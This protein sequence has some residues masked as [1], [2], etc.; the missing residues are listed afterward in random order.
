MKKIFAIAGIVFVVFVAFVALFWGSQN[1]TAPLLPPEE[2]GP[3]F[4]PRP[5]YLRSIDEAR[6]HPDFGTYIPSNIPERFLPG[7]WETYGVYDRTL[8]LR[9]HVDSNYFRGRIWWE[10]RSGI[11][12]PQNCPAI[13][14]E[15]LTLDIIQDNAH[16]RD[17]NLYALPYWEIAFSVR[18]DDVVIW[19]TSNDVLPEEALAIFAEFVES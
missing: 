5:I 14:A 9:W 19:F 3:L 1:E 7:T 13:L 18:F 11:P 15:E 2:D 10:V 12:E 8:Y 4:P 16:W 17:R 6:L